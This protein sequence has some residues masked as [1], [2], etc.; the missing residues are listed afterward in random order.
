MDKA[1][2]EEI[3]SPSVVDGVVEQIEKLIIAG[4]LKGG[5]KLPSERELAEQM[6]I[7]RPKIRD[8][9]KDLEGRGLLEVRHGEGT[10]VAALTGT[11]LSPAMIDLFSKHPEA[12]GGYIEFRRE[13]EGFA[14]YV[15][16]VR[17][18]D[19]DR[20]IIA[21]IM[22]EMEAA[23]EACDR[24]RELKLDV[25]LHV[26]IVDAAHNPLLVHV[27]ASIYE[28]ME[29]AILHGRMIQEGP[30]SAREALLGQ[31][32][33]IVDAILARD[34]QAASAAAEEHI[35]AVE[36]SYRERSSESTRAEIARKRRMLLEMPTPS[37][38]TGRATRGISKRSA[39]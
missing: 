8:A 5:R 17:A 1:I 6:G 27:M 22:Q 28:L 9:I 24:T 30:E 32:R 33:A 20:E 16:A 29:R 10:F 21:S 7:S 23:H 13:V 3:D 38:A 19:A 25:G 14:A 11:A 34:P 12:F 35:N 36:A 39:S 15:A 26:A 2:F 4:V 18:T 31:H 37:L